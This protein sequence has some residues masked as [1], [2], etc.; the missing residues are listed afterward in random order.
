MHFIYCIHSLFCLNPQIFQSVK[1]MGG[2]E[3]EEKFCSE[4]QTEIDSRFEYFAKINDTKRSAS[5]T[6]MTL[7][8]KQTELTGKMQ[9]VQ[10]ELV[11]FQQSTSQERAQ[12]ETALADMVQN[13]KELLKQIQEDQ[14]DRSS[15][16]NEHN[17]LR[18]KIAETEAEFAK[19]QQSQQQYQQQL[20]AMEAGKADMTRQ[21]MQAGHQHEMEMLQ[22][23]NAM[24]ANGKKKKGSWW[25]APFNAI[26]MGMASTVVDVFKK[27]AK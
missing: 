5:R 24:T 13:E 15:L 21:M 17:L 19:M 27:I 7:L 1:R 11:N 10:Q 22:F 23:Q 6:K 20:L 8:A 2:K 4:L 25:Q 14:A 16:I 3:Y 12:M 18:N 26:T 9:K